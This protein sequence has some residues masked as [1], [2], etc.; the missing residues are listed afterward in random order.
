MLAMCVQ[1]QVVAT[2]DY[3]SP[4]TTPNGSA[5]DISYGYNGGSG[6]GALTYVSGTAG[7]VFAVNNASTGG[8]QLDGNQSLGEFSGGNSQVA[9]R[10]LNSPLSIGNF[11]FDAR[12]D[13]SNTNN[14]F[15]GLNIDT[16]LGSGLGANELLSFGLTS[17]NGNGSF[18]ITDSTGTH[19]VS[20]GTDNELRG[21]SFHFSINFNTTSG[22]YT[23]TI[24]DNSNGQ[25]GTE[26]GS[27]DS[28][29]TG[30]GAFKL[31]NLDTDSGTQN[32]IVDN[33]VFSAVPEPS[34]LALLGGSSILIAFF[35]LRRRK[36]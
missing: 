9:G 20:V 26:S 3:E 4:Y 15:T 8:R 28:T 23:L 36:A 10:T 21:G 32:L 25:T 34:S 5:G 27:L 19:S 35:F 30:V 22:A 31:G 24:T 2:D 29:G 12:W 18:L 11:S 6:F 17:T 14:A 16:A 13:I 1:A 33:T 7:G